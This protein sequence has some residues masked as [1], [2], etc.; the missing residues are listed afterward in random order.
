M[1]TDKPNPDGLRLFTFADAQR[2]TGLSRRALLEAE[3][4][5]KLRTV[6]VRPGRNLIPERE[7]VQFALPRGES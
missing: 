6:E 2:L 1:M 7:L 5:G 3:L 4:A